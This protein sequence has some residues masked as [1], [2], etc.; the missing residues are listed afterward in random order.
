M[1]QTSL[2]RSGQTRRATRQG[3]DH[4]FCAMAKMVRSR[5][6]SLSHVTARSVKMCATEDGTVRR[7]V[8]NCRHE[9]EVEIYVRS[10]KRS[11]GDSWFA[12][13]T[14]LKPR[15]RRIMVI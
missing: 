15:F 10:S 3:N 14:V 2:T 5:K 1:P 6:R 9:S 4:R 7:L 12:W 13:L 11:I 8:T